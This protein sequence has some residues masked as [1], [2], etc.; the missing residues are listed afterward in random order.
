MAGRRLAGRRF[1]FGAV[2]G[3]LGALRREGVFVDGFE[4]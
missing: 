3:F 2:G 1:A 4:R